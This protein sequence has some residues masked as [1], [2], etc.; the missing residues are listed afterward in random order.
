MYGSEMSSTEQ[1]QR[2]GA[3]S[4]GDIAQRGA[5]PLERGLAREPVNS[6]IRTVCLIGAGASILGSLMMQIRGRKGEALFIGQWAPTLIAFALWYQ[7]VKSQS[8]PAHR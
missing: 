4:S 5:E 2:M 1:M 6:T 7:I 3:T 8:Q